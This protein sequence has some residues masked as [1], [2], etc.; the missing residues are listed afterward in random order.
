MCVHKV[1]AAVLV[2][3][4]PDRAKGE[5]PSPIR[6]ACL[7]ASSSIARASETTAFSTPAIQA[8][9]YTRSLS[10]TTSRNGLGST[11]IRHHLSSNR[12]TQQQ[13]PVAG[14]L[15]GGRG[16]HCE[17]PLAISAARERW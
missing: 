17:V 10:R 1:N 2:G 6:S 5:A 12:F 9:N 7:P 14:P 13:R 8:S 4:S 3:Q 11:S 15:R 16:D